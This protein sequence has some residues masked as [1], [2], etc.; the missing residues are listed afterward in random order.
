MDDNDGI[1]D[2]DI[3]LILSG[4]IESGKIMRGYYPNESGGTTSNFMKSISPHVPG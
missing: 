3:A 2:A 4:V 1:I